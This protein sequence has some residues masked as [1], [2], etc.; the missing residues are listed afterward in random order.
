M[1]VMEG[2]PKRVPLVEE[3][4]MTP[5][6][7]AHTSVNRFVDKAFNKY[8]R[9]QNEHGGCL[10]SKSKSLEF[11]LDHVEEEIIDMWH[12][13]QAFR[14]AMADKCV[15]DKREVDT[16]EVERVMMDKALSERLKHVV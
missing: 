10:M 7:I 1:H 13:V 8:M 16:K 14:V 12:Y 9:G 5:E 11:F 6:D 15:A 4:T 2:E 3:F